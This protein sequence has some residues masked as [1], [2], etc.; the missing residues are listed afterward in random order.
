MSW[1]YYEPK[2]E[3]EKDFQ[4][5]A[6]PWAGHKHFAYDLIANTKP[7]RAVE[8][9]THKGTSLFSFAQSAKDN[10][11]DV[12]INAVDTWE[13]EKH[14]GFYGEEV[15][16]G[17]KDIKEKYYSEVNINLLRKT[18]DEAVNDFKDKSI[19]VLHIDGLHTYEAVKHDF[20]TWIGKVSDNGIVLFHDI[21]V[22]EKDFGVYK[23][24]NELKKEYKTI[25]FHNSFGLG[26]LFKNDELAKNFKIIESEM[27]MHYLYIHEVS[28]MHYINKQEVHIQESNNLIQQKEVQIQQKN[29]QLQQKEIQIQQ[30]NNQLQQK[31]QQ[32]KHMQSSKF[33]K[34]RNIYIHYKN[35]IKQGIKNPKL[36]F[37][38]MQKRVIKIKFFLKKQLQHTKNKTKF[39]EGRCLFCFLQSIVSKR[40]LKEYVQCKKLSF[41]KHKNPKVSIIIPVYNQLGYTLNALYSIL[42]NVQ[43]ISYEVIVIDDK[44]TD[45]T[46]KK[47]KQIKNII[48]IRNQKNIGFL[49][50]CN[51]A[52]KSAN[53]K[54][55]VLLNNDTEVHQNWLKT[56]VDV[57]KNVENVGLVGSK[58]IYPNGKLQEAGG[59]V[60]KN[61]DVWNYG[62][63]ANPNNYE[64]NYLKDVDYC[65]AASVMIKKKTWEKVGGFDEIYAPAYFE[66][67][68]LAFRIRE[69][70]LRVMYQ[71]LSVVTHFEGVS[72]GT[73]IKEGTKKYQEINKKTFFN[74]WQKKLDEENCDSRK[75]EVFLAKDRS[76]NKKSILYIENNVPTFDK[77]A[78]SFITFKY[79]KILKNLGYK[80]IF[81]PQNLDGDNLYTIELQQN[82]IEVVYGDVDFS[83]FIDNNG[84]NIDIT[85]IARPEIA[86]LFLDTVKDK[87]N[88]Y[89]AYMAHD[90]HF[91]RMEREQCVQDGKNCDTHLVEDMKK[92]ERHA[93][94]KSDI[95]MLFSDKEIEVVKSNFK[96][97]NPVVIPWIQEIDVQNVNKW[98]DREG[99][100]FLGGFRH[101]PNVDAVKWLHNK[102]RPSI[103]EKH[104]NI[105]FY[106]LG[107]NMPDEIKKLNS[108]M[109]QCIGFVDEQ[110][111]KFYLNK[112]RIFV[113]PLRYGAGFKGKIAMALGHGIP[114]VT[115][116]IGAEGIGLVHEKN[117]MISDD[118]QGFVDNIN[119]VYFN[120]KLW[121]SIS[122]N[123]IKHVKQNFSVE[124]AQNTIKEIFENINYEK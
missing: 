47:L 61:M 16:E 45:N 12:E 28:R 89:I 119:K 68:D 71:P 115:T 49:R 15:I 82:G 35:G 121:N 24:W 76:C 92:K 46:N 114:V 91:L 122:E 81:W 32:I 104:K 3:Y 117:A 102:I 60:W 105:K 93:F 27:Q 118:E 31:I 1:K 79:L 21:K 62:R 110:E 38:F 120:E 95:A 85:I 75:S 5:I 67:T 51:K 116:N 42:L 56:L 106:M 63:M 22:K 10:K 98:S 70:G 103:W 124:N 107:S 80:V 83:D 41:K 94:E 69:E 87:T 19:D 58:L 40:S 109:F 90:L 86:D 55:I 29:N 34:M 53:G 54:Y 52:A 9:G 57:F 6:W 48:Y 36:F 30:K 108:D 33:W 99:I 88:A 17:V 7:K 2:F 113:A 66:D 23:L 111:L 100:V 74:R 25:E 78:G 96:N 14:A 39:R 112:S 59:I 64:F 65:S 50:S 77:D 43:G 4:D 72:C 84:K 20:D 44:S 11:I 18:F 8:L 97:S 123:G 13:G 73:D 37:I 26:I 101:T